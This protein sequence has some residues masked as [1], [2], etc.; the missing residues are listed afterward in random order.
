LGH[1]DVLLSRAERVADPPPARLEILNFISE[2]GQFLGAALARLQ[3]QA[4]QHVLGGLARQIIKW[5]AEPL[6]PE[7][8]LQDLVRLIPAEIE[9]LNQQLDENT[10]LRTLRGRAN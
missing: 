9:I 7:A 2:R 8:I 4:R 3:S 6:V 1:R 5:A 10:A